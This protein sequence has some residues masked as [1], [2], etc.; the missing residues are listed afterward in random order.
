MEC[1][2]LDSLEQLGYDGPLTE[3]GA[4]LEAARGGLSSVQYVGLCRWLVSRLKPLC[5]LEENIT[6]GSDDLESLEVD[7]RGLLKEL[8]CPYDASAIRN[9]NA[10]DYLKFILFLSSELQAAQIIISGRHDIRGQNGCPASRDLREICQTL[11]MS[12][13]KGQDAVDVL[14]LIQNK[15]YTLVEKCPDVTEGK[16]AMKKALSSE[17]WE[18]LRS[19]NAT[20]SAEYECRRR[21][22]I[23]RLDVTVQSFGWSDRAKAKVDSMARAY[24]P[25]RHVLRAETTVDAAALLAAREDI[26]NVVKT[27]SGASRVNTA[28]AVN[29]VQMGRVPDRGGRPSEIEAPP[30]EMPPW[31]KRQDGGS[32]WG[33]HGQGRGGWQESRGDRWVGGG[34]GGGWWG[35]GGGGDWHGGTRNHGGKRGRYQY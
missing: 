16:P 34:G 17:Q 23:K 20:M 15:V 7:M 5:D 27:S 1:D 32:N 4:L 6:T 11:S 19:V 35:G 2:I 31:Q 14:S 22:L 33:G 24:Q 25:K 9:G 29:K 21:M 13:C 30:P 26:F 8:C 18:T 28:C 12:N 3:E 10:K